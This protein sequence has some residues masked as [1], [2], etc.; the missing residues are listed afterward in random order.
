MGYIG[1]RPTA[2]PLT[3]ADIQ[4]GVITA[5]DL[6]ANSVDSSELVDNSV[7]LAKMAGGTDGNIISYD[8]S[9]DPT[10]IATGDDGQV[11]TS[12]GAGQP[13]AFEAVAAGGDLS[14]GGDT[15]GADKTIGSNDTYALS[16]ETDGNVAMKIDANGYIFKPLQPCFQAYA[17]A[18]QNIT[19]WAGGYV[20]F[21]GEAFDVGSNFDTGTGTFTAPVAGKYL[22]AVKVTVTDVNAW[23]RVVLVPTG[24]QY[25]HLEELSITAGFVCSFTTIVSMAAN[26]T[27]RILCYPNDN[28]FNI[29]GS[30]GSSYKQTTFCGMLVA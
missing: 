15:F 21:G 9:G 8:A 7:T 14:F 5:A 25:W 22:F 1:N 16:F 13:P 6:G 10:A 11:L 2:V 12:A 29:T 20:D 17:S 18:S 27:A 30:A 28:D 4:D 24:Q 19:G 26:D 3:S 23:C